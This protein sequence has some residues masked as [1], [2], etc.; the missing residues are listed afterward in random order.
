VRGKKINKSGGAATQAGTNYQ[1]RVAAW[2]CVQILAEQEAQPQWGLPADETL[3]L[4]L[5]ETEESVDDTLIKTALGSCVLMNAK[6]K[7]TASTKAKSHF[8]SAISQFVRQFAESMKEDQNN[9]ETFFDLKRGRLVLVT[10]SGSSDPVK[11][12]LPRVLSRLRD[13]T[14]G[15]RI[16]AA[17][18]SKGEREVLS[19]L[20]L[21]IKSAWRDAGDGE[22]TEEKERRLLELIRV[23]ILDVDEDERDELEAKRTLRASVLEETT[24]ADLAWNTLIACCANKA[25][26][27]SGFNRRSLQQTLLD[28]G[29]R[30]KVPRSY[31]KDIEQLQ[32]Y[33]EA[34]MR[35]L[36]R[37]SLI[38]I[39]DNVLKIQRPSTEALQAAIEQQ[40][41][42]VVG[43]PGAGKSGTLHDLVE[44]LKG[45]KRD[46]IFIA[47]GEV[48]ANSL[49]SL[50]QELNLVH[51]ILEV[52]N[53]WPGDEAAFLVIDA[54]D[55]ARLGEKGRAFY[56][57]IADIINKRGRW[58]VLA[59]IRKFDLRYHT[60]LRRLFAGRPPTKYI[61]KEFPNIC[62]F[63]VPLFDDP[64][65]WRQIAEQSLE[66][67]KLF[68]QADDSLRNLLRSPFNLRLV[69][70]LLGNNTSL[71]ELRPLQTQIE[72]LEKYWQ[73]RVIRNDSGGDGREIV[74][75]RAVGAM[76]SNR[77]LL[78]NRRD[79]TSD[80]GMGHSLEDLLSS[81]LL[82]ELETPSGTSVERNVLKFPHHILFDYAAA[83]LLFRGLPRTLVER[84]EMD[85]DLVLA[86]RP[87][88]VLHFQYLWRLDKELFWDAV[89]WV[90]R[91]QHIPQ[92]G[93]LIGSSVAAESMREVED[94]APL[95]RALSS[96]DGTQREAREQSLRHVTGTL[97]TNAVSYRMTLL[98]ESAPPWC[99]LLDRCITVSTSP[100][101]IYSV[102]SVLI[103][104]CDHPEKFTDE[105]RFF[106]GHVARRL[107]GYALSAPNW[108]SFLVVACQQAVCRTFESDPVASE[109]L[110]RCCLTPEHV[111]AHGHEELFRLAEEIERLMPLDPTL[112]EDIY[113]AAFTNFNNSEEKTLMAPSRIMLFTSTVKQDFHMGQFNLATKYGGFL[114]AAPLHATRALIA[115]L[116]SYVAEQEEER[117]K[118]DEEFHKLLKVS[119][120]VE[121]V[122]T[123]HGFDFNGQPA[124]IKD[125]RSDHWDSWARQNDEP[126]TLLDK[127]QEYLGRISSDDEHKDTRQQILELVRREN[128]NAVLWRRLLICGAQHPET[129][130]HEVRSLAWA[131]PVLMSGDT[132][133]E[134]GEFLKA[135]FDK[136]TVGDREK[137]ERAILC[138]PGVVEVKQQSTADYTRAQLLA[139]LPREAI[140][141]TEAKTLI[142]TLEAENRLPST[143][144]RRAISHGYGVAPTEE[145]ILRTQGVPVEAP[146]NQRIQLLME[147]VKE[148]SSAHFNTAPTSEEVAAIMPSLRALRD[149]LTNA[150]EEGVDKT[151]RDLAWGHLA[152]TGAASV[153]HENWSCETGDG[154]FIKRLLLDASSYPEPQPQEVGDDHFDDVPTWGTGARIGAACGLTRLTRHSSCVDDQVLATIEKLAVEDKVPAVRF[155]AATHLSSLYYTAPQLMW[156]LL[157]NISQQE[158]SRGILKF[159]LGGTLKR[160]APYRPDCTTIC[161][162]HIYNRFRED[163]AAKEIRKS[164]AGIFAGLYIWKAH[165][166]CKEIV[167]Q[168]VNNPHKHVVEA[169][170]IMFDV[171]RWLNLG[172]VDDSKPEDNVARINSFRLMESFL[173]SAYTHINTLE[174]KNKGVPFSSLDSSELEELRS[175]YRLVDDIGDQIYFAS[176]AFSHSSHEDKI[177]M[178][179][180]ERQRFLEDATDVLDLLAESGLAKTA[181]HLLITLEFFI[182]YEPKMIFLLIGKVVGNAK[183]SGYQYE[184]MAVGLIVRVV[185]QF[186]ANYPHLLRDSQECR[187]ALI[188]IL[189]TFVEAGWPSAQRLTYGLEEIFR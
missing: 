69:G 16:I 161:V 53:N 108:D 97:V 74:L 66:I 127:F 13:Q 148:F 147:P 179:R 75:T 153:E 164:C 28:Q 101:V 156:R 175:L 32:K 167:E 39:G 2:V 35:S 87:S 84:L 11:R 80:Q 38:R 8:G 40:S 119:E 41:I 134:A 170:S 105:Q 172:S 6:H 145:D 67:T 56:K 79:V 116:E 133:Q 62:H 173:R 150:E 23:Q 155:Q 92:I 51:D 24:Q 149:V 83:R 25:A 158:R 77:S 180:P 90:I 152:R 184:S 57:L 102:R 131:T 34:T 31:R 20:R 111:I 44:H 112:V 72:L 151:F 189:D 55:A 110:L 76:V 143:D 93:K 27:R 142:E 121:L 188:D 4:I 15:E 46:V 30:L 123:T 63:N 137:V 86:I 162:E 139:Y 144:S 174:E 128:R 168:I 177:P 130:G 60:D 58:R 160:L 12:S 163:G 65:E 185:E 166:R 107:L 68:I 42:V 36:Q 182:S 9:A 85:V 187:R 181:H 70:E 82:S 120:S 49:G 47:V 165:P 81:H 78:A 183:R 64:V 10:S 50:R 171:R 89:F 94:F 136:F 26:L 95:L 21:Q 126:L 117:R 118:R 135:A 91:S 178:G 73:E 104:M 19:K 88:L 33:S 115:A 176:G 71:D 138:L 52:L 140:I 98:G 54:L 132:T 7:V 146:Q 159:L 14:K 100:T 157:E 48:A 18:T 141:T 96:A 5:C 99:V 106:A 186:I 17:A 1:N 45:E 113:R 61:D 103:N 169:H 154:V 59:S 22:L 29:I 114:E 3:E 125:D 129:L 43:E 109:E 122:E 124:F 37:D